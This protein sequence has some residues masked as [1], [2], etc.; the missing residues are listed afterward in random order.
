MDRWCEDRAF[1]RGV[2]INLDQCWKLAQAWYPERMKPGWRR[3][4]PDE[5]QAVFDGLGLVGE[6]WRV[7]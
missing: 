5:S 2:V 7:A 6:F 4:S 3:K 1:R